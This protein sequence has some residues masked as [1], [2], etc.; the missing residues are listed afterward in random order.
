M[1]LFDKT[2]EALK[3]LGVPMGNLGFAYTRTA[4]DL[5]NK[6]PNLLR[7][8]TGEDGL[9]GQLARKYNTIPSRVE[10]AIRHGVDCADMQVMVKYV[11]KTEKRP[12]NRN[13]IAALVYEVTKDMEE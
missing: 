6:D 3:E 2:T 7:M 11:G 5:I 12:S 1:K 8:I 10:R 9:Y 13:F 4:V